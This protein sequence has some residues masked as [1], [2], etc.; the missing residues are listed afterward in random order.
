MLVAYKVMVLKCHW[1]WVSAKI[2]D[3][4]MWLG[5]CIDEVSH[6]LS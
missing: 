4:I 6:I 1:G 2:G 3:G 5:F